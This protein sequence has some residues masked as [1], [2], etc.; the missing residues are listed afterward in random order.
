M[1]KFVLIL[2]ALTLLC[3]LAA[4]EEKL[5]RFEFIERVDEVNIRGTLLIT[6]LVDD[7]ET[8]VVYIRTFGEYRYSLTP[9]IMVDSFGSA[10][11]GVYD[12][13]TDTIEPLEPY[14]EYDDGMEAFG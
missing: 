7:V 12:P 4:A 10:T 1:K 3:G 11:V 5:N 14:L 8:Y 2:A 9:Y 6:D 13:R